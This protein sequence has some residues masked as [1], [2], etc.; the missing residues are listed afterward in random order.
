MDVF[1]KIMNGDI[2]SFTL[3]EDDVVKVFLDVNPE[4]NGHTLVVPKEHYTDLFDIKDDVLAHIFNVA[5][6]M[7]DLFKEKL[8]SDGLTLVQNN[9]IAQEVKHFHLHLIPQY[10]Y[11]QELVEVEDVYHQ[12]TD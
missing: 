12:L 10:G 2:P 5:K 4:T 11:K 1:C 6:K 9:G 8:N 3:Y 7:N